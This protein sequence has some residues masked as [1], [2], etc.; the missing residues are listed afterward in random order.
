M[1]DTGDWYFDTR[2]LENRNTHNRTYTYVLATYNLAKCCAEMWHETVIIYL[3]AGVPDVVR[4]IIIV[5]V[6]LG[7]DFAIYRLHWLDIIFNIDLS[8]LIG[9]IIFL[10][11]CHRASVLQSL[12]CIQWKLRFVV[13]ENLERSLRHRFQPV[14]SFK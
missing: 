11:R 9:H 10:L 5:I 6:R 12:S 2:N 1:S 14:S 8:R 4:A 3:L 13:I 7:A